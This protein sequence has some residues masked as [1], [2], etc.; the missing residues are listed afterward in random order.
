MTGRLIVTRGYI[1]VLPLC[2]SKAIFKTHR[3]LK[4]TKKGLFVLH[5]VYP[6]SVQ[7]YHENEI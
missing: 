7:I 6:V 4:I 1:K 3:T 5:S 2:M